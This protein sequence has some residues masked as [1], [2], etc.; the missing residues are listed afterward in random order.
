MRI[1]VIA[2]LV[3]WLTLMT[4]G[5][6]ADGSTARTSTRTLALTVLVRC[7]SCGEARLTLI[8]SR[9]RRDGWRDGTEVSEIPGCE[10]QFEPGESSV[11]GEPGG[12]VTILQ[13]RVAKGEVYRLLLEPQHSGE[14]VVSVTGAVEADQPCA[15]EGGGA[16]VAAK[17]SEWRIRCAIK[18]SGCLASVENTARVGSAPPSR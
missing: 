1:C 6:V 11:D 13:I 4:L 8:D 7:D 17:L 14:A 15:A 12:A 10:R 3:P 18:G 2:A 16:V 5:C 9:G